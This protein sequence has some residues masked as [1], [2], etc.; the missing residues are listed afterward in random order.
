MYT[1]VNQLESHIIM[2]KQHQT[3][4]TKSL[5]ITN[6]TKNKKKKKTR[7][8]KVITMTLPD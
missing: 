5:P 4:K 3:L 8:K 7:K 2:N 6:Q 1:F